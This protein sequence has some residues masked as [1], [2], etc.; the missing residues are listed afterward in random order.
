MR[1]NTPRISR[2]ETSGCQRVHATVPILYLLSKRQFSPSDK[3]SLKKV[4]YN[5]VVLLGKEFDAYYLSNY[6]HKV[7]GHSDE[8]ICADIGCFISLIQ[9]NSMDVEVIEAELPNLLQK[10]SKKLNGHRALITLGNNIGITFRAASI[11]LI[12]IFVPSEVHWFMKKYSRNRGK[13]KF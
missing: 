10:H 5:Q 1:E 9:A 3:R 11:E 8:V 6:N 7:F 12:A 4:I 2:G 13:H